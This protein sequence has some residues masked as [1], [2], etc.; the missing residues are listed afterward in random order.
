MP[1]NALG[2]RAFFEINAP[3]EETC[4]WDCPIPWVLY[5]K[6]NPYCFEMRKNG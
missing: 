4:F 3:E 6:M 1:H 5:P 2:V